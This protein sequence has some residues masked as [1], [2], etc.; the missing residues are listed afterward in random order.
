[1]NL[2]YPD[3][4]LDS[5]YRP[6]PS[7]SASRRPKLSFRGKILSAFILLVVLLVAVSALNPD[8]LFTLG[9]RTGVPTAPASGYGYATSLIG[10]SNSDINQRMADMKATGVTW[11]RFDV[12]WKVVQPTKGGGYDW[13]TYDAMAQAAKSNGLN[14][15]M[16]VD[17]VPDWAAAKG[18]NDSELCSPANPIQF[19]QFAGAVAKRFKSDGVHDFEIWNEPNVTFRFEPAANPA[20]YTRMLKDSYAA[21]K[22]VDAKDVVVTAG[23]SPSETDS[24][25]YSP[26]DYLKA[27]YADGAHGWFDALGAHPYTYPAD[28]AQHQSDDAWGEMVTEHSIMAAHGDGNKQIWITEFGAPTNGPD[29]T[30]YVSES[31]QAQIATDAVNTF[32]SYSWAGPMFWYNYT[33]TGTSTSTNENFFGLVRA[34]GSQK[35]AYSAFEQAISKDQ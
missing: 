32:R 19:G 33:D 29:S 9:T 16:I 8:L 12:S 34:D 17:F 21:I 35:P 28:P 20:L 3:H 23:A 1:M 7:G 15:L 6:S 4:Q 31:F 27:M 26:T 25:D 24:A 11:V 2:E 22:R 13:S 10:M 30:K 14:V 18:C 5:T